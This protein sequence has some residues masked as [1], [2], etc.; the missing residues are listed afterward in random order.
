MTNTLFS[1]TILKNPIIAF[2]IAVYT[3]TTYPFV[4]VLFLLALI[5]KSHW[6]M[7]RYI[8]DHAEKEY[9]IDE[10]RKKGNAK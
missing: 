5:D 1:K 8:R 2:C 3:L 10:N 7:L 4:L 6:F 9:L